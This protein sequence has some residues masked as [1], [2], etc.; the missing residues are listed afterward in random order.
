[1]WSLDSKI[2]IDWNPQLQVIKSPNSPRKNE[3]CFFSLYLLSIDTWLGG[4]VGKNSPGWHLSRESNPRNLH[5]G[6]VQCML[7]LKERVCQ[8]R[9][10]VRPPSLVISTVALSFHLCGFL[11]QAHPCYLWLQPTH[12]ITWCCMIVRINLQESVFTKG[13]SGG[14]SSGQHLTTWSLQLL[15]Q[16]QIMIWKKELKLGESA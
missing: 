15:L 8:A 2:S 16:F 13:D 4:R 3:Y 11:C 12:M 10:A 1:M 14:T 9:A 5:H 7:V 6:A